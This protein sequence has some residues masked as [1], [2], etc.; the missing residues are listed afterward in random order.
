VRPASRARLTISSAPADGPPIRRQASHRATSRREIGW[1]ISLKIGAR[2]LD[3]RQREPFAHHRQVPAAE[4]L[5]RRLGHRV[6]V[7]PD[8]GGVVVG[9]GPVRAGHQDQQG[10]HGA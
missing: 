2:V 3:Q 1:K 8:Q 7:L 10:R 5:Q 6:D 4:Q 9:A